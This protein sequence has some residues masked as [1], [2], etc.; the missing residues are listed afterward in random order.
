[1]DRSRPEPPAIPLLTGQILPTPT[2]YPHPRPQASLNLHLHI[3]TNTPHIAQDTH[4]H[5]HAPYSSSPS[6]VLH[7]VYVP[8]FFLFPR[9][10]LFIHTS[11]PGLSSPL[12]L[13]SRPRAQSLSRS[14]P[15]RPC[16]RVLAVAAMY[17]PTV[18][19][20]LSGFRG[21]SCPCR[22]PLL[23]IPPTVLP[24]SYQ[25]LFALPLILI[26]DTLTLRL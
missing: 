7:F 19:Q 10:A 3:S 22:A 23:L 14:S 8:H 20:S 24:H 11:R 5:V 21:L 4:T 9:V 15:F 12:S 2:L 18:S 6:H 16:L 25:S 17:F 13:I 1:M 26:S